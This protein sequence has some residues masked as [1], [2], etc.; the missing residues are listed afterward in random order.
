[1]F[2][3]IIKWLL[4]NESKGV[5]MSVIDSFL[6]RQDEIEIK[7]LNKI[8][9]QIEALESEIQTLSD[10]DLSNK[11]KEFRDRLDKGE[12]LDDLLVEA[13][14]VAREATKRVLGMRQYRVQLIGGIV[15]H[16]GKIAEMK[17]GEGKTLVAVAPC[18]LNALI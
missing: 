10:L 15:L 1:M 12:T 3:G 5:T 7:K 2:C 13:F 16:Q 18:Y 11:T 4:T 6:N 8:V 14:A 17:T 9:D